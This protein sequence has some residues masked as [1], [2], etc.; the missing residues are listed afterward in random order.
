M[1]HPSV[2][3]MVPSA[4]TSR[5]MRSL[6]GGPASVAT[7]YHHPEARVTQSG[8]RTVCGGS[9]TD[10][11][12]R[13]LGAALALLS[14]LACCCI[15][16]HDG[17]AGTAASRRCCSGDSISIFFWGAPSR[18]A[19][20]KKA[21]APPGHAGPQK[22]VPRARTVAAPPGRRPAAAAAAHSPQPAAGA[23]RPATA[24][25][26]APPARRELGIG[27]P[28]QWAIGCDHHMLAKAGLPPAA[29]AL[30][31]GPW[32]G[33]LAVPTCSMRYSSTR[34][35]RTCIVRRQVLACLLGRGGR[36]GDIVMPRQDFFVSYGRSY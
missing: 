20:R 24:P 14:L 17:G 7:T 15:D 6:T 26:A 29:G 12:A 8:G 3:A 34:I 31:L 25:P 27:G 1:Q 32:D 23:A 21:A 33:R 36:H 5:S 28:Q 22:L 2:W 35:R 13:L 10:C 16:H 11:R 9:P 19:L 30:V 18:A 4:L